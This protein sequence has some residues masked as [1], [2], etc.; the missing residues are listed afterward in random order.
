MTDGSG[1]PDSVA[2]DGRPVTVE[3]EYTN[4]NSD[5][6][7]TN[8]WTFEGLSP[9][10]A[11]DRV[12]GSHVPLQATLWRVGVWYGHP[13]DRPDGGHESGILNSGGEYED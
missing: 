6:T 2:H 3:A 12:V 8:Q 10:Q 9:K 1:T 7:T 13:E 11:K 4:A 5:K